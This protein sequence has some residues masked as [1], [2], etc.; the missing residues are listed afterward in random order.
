MKRKILIVDDEIGVLNS[1]KRCLRNAPY[2]VVTAENASQALELLQEHHVCLIITDVNMPGMDG[3]ELIC[4]ANAISPYSIKMV[5]S[6][7]T[8]IEMVIDAVN[9]GHIWRY[10]IKPW[11]PEDI[12]ITIGNAIDYYNSQSEKRKLTQELEI[13]NKEL[14]Q[15]AETLEEQ[16]GKRTAHIQSE[17]VMMRMLLNGSDLDLFCK[18]IIPYFSDLFNAESVSV[19]SNIDNVGYFKDHHEMISDNGVM[20]Q[21]REALKRT[22][23]YVDDQLIIA[24]VIND[25]IVYGGIVIKNYGVSYDDVS[26][27]YESYLA[28]ITI[29]LTHHTMKIQTPQMLNNI[30]KL[31]KGLE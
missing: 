22:E 20:I 3:I 6:A 29:A 4:R 13:K 26:S 17:L 9:R 23:V 12:R 5:L 31:I 21:V 28:L 30:D 10:M 2:E 14:V 11:Q 19:F 24:P 7:Y 8:D 25:G 1:L 27:E 18:A 16:V 15:W